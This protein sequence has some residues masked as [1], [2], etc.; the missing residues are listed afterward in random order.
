MKQESRRG[1][2]LPLLAV[3][4]ILLGSPA[5]L[6]SEDC[7][8]ELSPELT[9]KESG[10]ETSGEGDRYTF[11]VGVDIEEDCAEVRFELVA[12][13][14]TA[15]GEDE[16]RVEPGQVRLSDGST[17]YLMHYNLGPGEDLVEWEFKL[18]AC[19]PCVLDAPD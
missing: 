8:A 3:F 14:Q 1:T 10:D 18:T 2:L 12:Q 9:R 4:L 11:S 7:D 13:V 6:A 19:N 17:T 16:T 5:A 15:D